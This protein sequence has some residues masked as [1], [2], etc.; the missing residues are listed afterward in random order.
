MKDYLQKI[1]LSALNQFDLEKAPEIQI[2]APKNAEHGDASTNIAM[3]LA[4]PLRDNPRK[5]AEQIIDALEYKESRI[6]AVEIAGPGFIN[7]RFAE[8]YLF[9]ELSA[10]LNENEDFGR[11]SA[12][13]NKRILVEFVSAN[14]TGP[15]TVGHGRN[16]VLGDTVARLLE[17]TGAEVDREYYFNDAGR[18]MRV[19]G[20]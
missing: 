12:N 3:L 2:E 7:F 20:E 15:L 5:I 1:I 11:T 9:E 18:Q 14:P 6:S 19:L 10:I 16:A 17:W 13:K 4:K 8:D